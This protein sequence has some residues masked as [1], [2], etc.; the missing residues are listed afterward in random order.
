MM[1]VRVIAPMGATIRGPVKL[2]LTSEQYGRRRDV[3]GKF[4]KNGIYEIDGDAAITLK[5]GEEIGIDDAKRLNKSLFEE[6]ESD[7]ALAEREAAEEA[8]RVA[9][10]EAARKLAESGGSG[11]GQGPQGGAGGAT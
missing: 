7:V 10:E 6:P 11:S 1:K 4:K 5:H 2:L 8:A 3:L 9:A